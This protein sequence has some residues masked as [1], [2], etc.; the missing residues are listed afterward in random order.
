MRF[1]LLPILAI[2]SF[3]SISQSTK[4]SLDPQIVFNNLKKELV[5]LKINSISDTVNLPFSSIRVLDKRYDTTTI[6]YLRNGK[7]IKDF[8]KLTTKNYLSSDIEV[9]IN[10]VYKKI[11][12]TLPSLLIVIRKFQFDT[13]YDF[14]KNLMTGSLPPTYFFALSID[15]FSFSN[16]EYIPLVKKDTVI[17]MLQKHKITEKGIYLG[18]NFIT[19]LND[20]FKTAISNPLSKKRKLSYAEVNE[21]YDKNFH[22][23]ILTSQQF[24]KGVYKNFDDFKKNSPSYINFEIRKTNLIDEIF[25]MEGENA[26][27]T[28]NIWGYCDGKD[29]FLKLGTNLF[30]LYRQ[31]NSFVLLG[32]DKLTH[33]VSSYNPTYND[34]SSPGANLGANLIGNILFSKDKF[35]LELIPLELDME[36]GKVY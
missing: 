25:I 28:R 9:F 16:N 5:E 27:P 22:E 20:L 13:D 14:S 35:K 21:Y 31:G 33:Q 23:P 12:T 11:N 3:S 34:M 2:A 19:A 18:Q 36:T 4:K 7:S 32:N 17:E 24:K 15:C 10:R 29:L 8:Y 26:I 30:Q 1:I 6:G